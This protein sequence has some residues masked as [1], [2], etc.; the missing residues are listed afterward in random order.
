[1]HKESDSN[2]MII[3]ETRMIIGY[4]IESYKRFGTEKKKRQ[5]EQ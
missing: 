2:A 3:M 1:M 4:L 5:R